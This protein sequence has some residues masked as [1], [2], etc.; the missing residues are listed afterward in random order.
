[1]ISE[2]EALLVARREC[3]KRKWVWQEP[4]VAQLKR[5]IWIVHTNWGSRGMNAIIYIDGEKGSVIKAT[6]LP[7]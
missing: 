3:E 7:R 5:H 1:M 4:V 6:Y 2:A